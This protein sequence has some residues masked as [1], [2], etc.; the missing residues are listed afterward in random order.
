MLIISMSIR[1]LSFPKSDFYRPLICLH[2][3]TFFSSFV[4]AFLFLM[5]FSMTVSDL[6]S[7][8]P[9]KTACSPVR[10]IIAIPGRFHE[11]W[12]GLDD[13]FSLLSTLLNSDA[14][15]KKPPATDVPAVNNPVYSLFSSF[16]AF[17]KASSISIIFPFRLGAFRIPLVPPLPWA[18]SMTTR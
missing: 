3:N 11:A 13:Y 1:S 17:F 5:H 9:V 2:Y 12:Q 15:Y 18:P 8:P 4:A 10:C 16:C 7:G 14:A 6:S